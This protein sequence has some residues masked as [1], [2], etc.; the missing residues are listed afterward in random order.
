MIRNLPNLEYP[1]GALESGYRRQHLRQDI[2]QCILLGAVW[3]LPNF[4]FFQINYQLYGNQALFFSL[5][6]YRLFL[7]ASIFITG[8]LIARTKSPV[9]YDRLIFAG[10]SVIL[11]GVLLT[12]HYHTPLHL[13]TM[14]LD[15]LIILS[16]YLMVPSR[17]RN[18]AIPCVVFSL[19]NILEHAMSDN[20]LSG[21]IL[22]MMVI[23]F[24]MANLLGIWASS[25]FYSYRR[26]QYEAQVR[27]YELR[28][29][30]IQN[31]L[32]D[33]LTG[34]SNRRH[35][36]QIAEAEFERFQ[37]YKRPFS[38]LMIDLDHFKHINDQ[39]GHPVGDKVLRDLAATINRCRRD[40]DTFGRLGGEEFALLLPETTL[41]GATDIAVR[42]RRACHGLALPAET[43]RRLTI[44]IG[45]TQIRTD[46]PNFDA[47]LAR[48]DETLYRAKTN[49]RDRVE[50]A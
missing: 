37:R 44:S 7:T 29:D 32:V 42:L 15:Y 8:L 5:S 16:I 18:K 50:V 30:L 12:N 13:H 40:T 33:Q 26:Q 14:G 17:L 23:S 31:A 43:A 41:S 2:R 36:F 48:A 46:D 11:G 20:A 9:S 25:H 34:V 4:V 3:L 1:L 21:P 38:L 47:V 10:S 6:G 22:T 28:K 19:V 24:A 49:G 39:F 27:A 45:V 35:F